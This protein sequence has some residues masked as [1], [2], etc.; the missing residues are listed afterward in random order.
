[1]QSKKKDN[2]IIIRL[3]PG[4][5][6]F[7]ELKNVCRKYEVKTAVVISGIGQLKQF[8]LGYFRKKGD[9]VSEYYEKAYEMISLTGNICNSKDGYEFHV[10]ACLGNEKKEAMGGHLIEG[11]VEIT[12]EISLLITDMSIERKT[13]E[14][15]GLRGLFLE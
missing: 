13:E 2:L 15:T 5:S 7:E 3:F 8:K 12:N 4:E 11:T 10:H 14:K 1:M 9:Y 6:I